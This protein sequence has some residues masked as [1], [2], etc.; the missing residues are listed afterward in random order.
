[1]AEDE[2][3]SPDENPSEP[4]TL[5]FLATHGQRN[6]QAPEIVLNAPPPSS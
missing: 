3:S 6:L 2:G 4:E 1:M 5:T